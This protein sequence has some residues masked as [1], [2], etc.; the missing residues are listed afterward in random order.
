MFTGIVQETGEILAKRQ[1]AQGATLEIGGQ[2]MGASLKTG[3]SV[4]I[5]GV[6]LTVSGRR[7]PAFEVQVTPET[8]RRTSLGIRSPGD[9]VNL[10]LAARLSDFLGG[11]LVQGHIDGTGSIVSVRPE[12]NSR[13]V[14]IQASSKILRYCT[15]KGS[16]TVNGVS[17]TISALHSDSFE[18]TIIPH[19]YEVTNFASLSTGDPVNL[20]ADVVSKYVETHVRRLLGLVLAVAFLSAST[21]LGHSFTLGPNTVLV[22]ESENKGQVS[23][24]V[25]RLERHRPDIV[26]EWES[27]SDQGTLHLL[28]E[29]VREAHRFSFS[30]LFKVGVDME[31]KDTMTVWLSERMYRDLTEEGEA[32]VTLNS[33]RA[34][35]KMQGEGTFTLNV[36]KE[37]KEIPVIHVQD[38]RGGR[39]TIHRDPGN[40]IL[41]EYTLR[42]FRRHLK[43]VSTKS[44]NRLRWIRNPPPVK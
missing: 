3:D 7:G 41:V 8:L 23:Q 19:T 11:H 16:V 38:S 32:R 12:G 35:M 2:Q 14:R 36:N 42:K 39:W 21:L 29:A 27:V 5:D 18:V 9:R 17:L 44:K 31:S 40:P 26:L 30:S 1:S 15:L 20:E 43:T 10:E 24:F 4:S 13:I 25:L 37:T 34:T 33:L 6:C 28:R 22:Y